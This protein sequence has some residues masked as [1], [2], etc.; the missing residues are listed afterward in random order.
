MA[1]TQAQDLIQSFRF[2]VADSDSFLDST[3]GFNNVTTPEV[4]LEVAEYREG[5]RKY[6]LKQPGV[7]TVESCTLQRGIAK[8]ETNFYDWLVTDLLGGAKYRTDLLIKVF[9]QVKTGEVVTDDPTRELTVYE[10]FP[11][12]VKIIGDLDATSSD[13]NI[14]EIEC[15]CEEV[16]LTKVGGNTP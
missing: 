3:A 12:R 9:D 7:P 6:T 5:N 1:R 13:I 14:Q 15:A 4:S 2:Q 11:N 16:A 8:A 10:A